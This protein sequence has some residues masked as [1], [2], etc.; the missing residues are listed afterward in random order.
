MQGEQKLEAGEVV[1]VEGGPGDFFYIVDQGEVVLL[2]EEGKRVSPLSI[3][4]AG[5]FFGELSVFTKQSARS[6]SAVATEETIVYKI[7]AEDVTKVLNVCPD[8]VEEI[9]QVISG[10]LKTSTEVMKEH[11]IISD[12]MENYMASKPQELLMYQEQIQRYR[13]ENG[14]KL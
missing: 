5:G 11:R 9:M 13:R 8:W 3:V 6:L 14:L 1:F 7:A 2:K 4:S 12:E 10:R